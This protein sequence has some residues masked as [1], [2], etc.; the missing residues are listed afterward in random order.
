MHVGYKYTCCIYIHGHFVEFVKKW[1][2]WHFIP[3]ITSPCLPFCFKLQENTSKI[4]FQ[5][6]F[7]C[8]KTV[9]KFYSTVATSYNI[10]LHQ[11]SQKCVTSSL[12]YEIKYIH[13][14]NYYT[15]VP[16]PLVFDPQIFSFRSYKTASKNG[17]NWRCWNY[18]QLNINWH[19]T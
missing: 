5:I 17:L 10:P 15:S 11:V 19:V 12:S 18:G 4:P 6:N 3:Y 8:W 16:S 7:C 9:I 13:R 1:Q 2:K 14:S